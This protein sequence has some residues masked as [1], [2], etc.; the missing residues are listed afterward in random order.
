M[1]NNQIQ[2]NPNIPLHI[3]TARMLQLTRDTYKN[4]GHIG[5]AFSVPIQSAKL[6][7]FTTSILFQCMEKIKRGQTQE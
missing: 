1:Q 4:Y 7:D 2:Y 6:T 3:Q 5:K